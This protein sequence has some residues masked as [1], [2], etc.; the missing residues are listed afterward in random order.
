MDCRRM[1]R[2]L[3]AGAVLAC[4]ASPLI[5]QTS[6]TSPYNLPNAPGQGRVQLAQPGAARPE[7][8][9]LVSQEEL[10]RV[11]ADWEQKT[12]RITKLRGTHERYEYDSVF[13]VE[14]RAVGKFWYE[15]PDKGRIDF[16]PGTVPEN[17]LNP[18]KRG[19]PNNEPYQVK[20]V[21]PEIWI[22]TGEEVIQ[23]DVHSKS[24]GRIEIPPH[25]QGQSIADG[26]IPFLFGMTADKLKARYRGLETGDMHDPDG[27]KGNQHRQQGQ[28][29]WTRPQYHI[30]AYPRLQSDAANWKRAEVILDAEFC[31]PTAI[32]LLDP[33]ETK[34]TVYVF[35]L[36]DMKANEKLP[37]VPNPF[38]PML[39][40]YKLTETHVAD[41]RQ[42]VIPAAN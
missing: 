9:V 23:I 7:P 29:G 33:A 36:A 39:R 5:A 32:R 13:L 21:D 14:T 22:C 35:R 30:V 2:C 12:S 34:E 10:E 38:K 42:P 16:E 8:P 24:Y 31:L 27:A 6:Q 11:L 18:L 41:P 26:P 1:L 37:W 15:T 28:G 40:G 17:G 19:G 4:F 25:Q 20:A 3:V